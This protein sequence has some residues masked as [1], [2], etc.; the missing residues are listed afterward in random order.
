M[1]C[2]AICSRN[3][4]FFWD[5]CPTGMN[6]FLNERDD[7]LYLK[8][9]IYMEQKKTDVTQIPGTGYAALLFNITVPIVAIP[10]LQSPIDRV[11]FSVASTRVVFIAIASV[12]AVCLYCALLP[13]RS[14]NNLRLSLL[15]CLST[16]GKVTRKRKRGEYLPSTS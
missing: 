13:V 2:Y 11:P 4:C 9:E 6:F 8:I 5:H 12:S 7:R 16:S 14:V 15:N 3:Y 10:Y 1:D